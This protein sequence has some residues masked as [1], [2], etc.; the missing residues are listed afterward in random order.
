MS[1]IDAE[2]PSIISEKPA[3]AGIWRRLAAFTIDT[4]ILSIPAFIVGFG[5]FNWAASLGQAGRLIGFFMLL[6]YFGYFDSGL[7]VG[8]TLGKQLLDI[9]VVGRTGAMLSP[10]QAMSRFIIIGIPFFLNGVWINVT[11]IWQQHLILA[12]L[13]VLIFGLGGSILYLF[14]FNRRTHQSL[15]DFFD[16]EFRYSI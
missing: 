2:E 9:K 6:L 16:G 13:T 14:I 11:S 1:D 10:V 7:G 8:Q 3:F 12:L 4:V 15:H 5:Y